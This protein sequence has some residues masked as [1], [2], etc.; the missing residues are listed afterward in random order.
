MLAIVVFVFVASVVS[1]LV[2]RAARARAEAQRGRAE[3]EALARLSGWLVAEEDPLAD[4]PR[5]APR[6]V[7]AARRSRSSGRTDQGWVMEAAAG[8]G[9]PDRS[10]TAA[11]D[12]IELRTAPSCCCEATACRRS[13][14][15]CCRAFAAHL[16]AAVR[17]RDLSEEA[18]EAAE[19]VEVDELR[20][21]ILQA[22]SHDL[23]TPLASIKAAASSLRQDDVPWSEEETERV[24]RHD[25]GGDRP[26]QRDGR[27]PPRHEPDPER[28]AEPRLRPGG[29]GRSGPA[30][31]REPP[32]Q[33]SCDP[34]GG[35][36]E[37]APG[38]GRR[39]PVGARDRQHRRQ[40]DGMD[41]RR[42]STSRIDRQLR[43]LT[44]ASSCG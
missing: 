30:R 24:P 4:A 39:R 6:H 13:P 26:A 20:T 14:A 7:R 5:S 2:D 25:R 44:A 31:A 11:S 17:A 41:A 22:V 34:V 37:P 27:Q 38:R 43:G 1:V 18:A 15:G 16:A 42:G 36:R 33:R 23:R 28:S 10:R 32:R 35:A 3:A 19:L 12:V 21:A 40:R 8:L 9:A 29:P